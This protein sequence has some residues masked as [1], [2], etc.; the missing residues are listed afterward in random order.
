MDHFRQHD[1]KPL[2]LEHQAHTDTEK[3]IYLAKTAAQEL[4]ELFERDGRESVDGQSGQ[5]RD[6]S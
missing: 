5:G 6:G 3:T 2:T 1:D 4:E